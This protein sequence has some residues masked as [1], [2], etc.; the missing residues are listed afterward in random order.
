MTLGFNEAVWTERRGGGGE[1]VGGGSGS[2]QLLCSQSKVFTAARRHILNV[3]KWQRA[4]IASVMGRAATAS[5]ANAP[6]WRADGRPAERLS[7]ASLEMNNRTREPD[8]ENHHMIQLSGPL[9]TSTFQKAC[10]LRALKH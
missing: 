8:P 2:G 3:M 9:S 4:A 7:D 10:A 5:F 1:V 6:A